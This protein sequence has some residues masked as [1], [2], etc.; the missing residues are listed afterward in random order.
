MDQKPVIIIAG[1]RPEL[2]KT[3]PVYLA[4]KKKKL[5]VLFCLTGQHEQLARQCLDLFGIVPDFDLKIMQA[6][7]G[8]F[9]VTQAVLQK[10][11]DIFT[12][13]KPACVLVQGD[14]TS[15]MAAALS[16]F[17]LKIPIGHIEA[18]LRTHDLY[19]PFPEEANRKII[20]SIAQF[21]FAPTE[22]ARQHLLAEHIPSEAIF[23]T[24]N[25]IVDA[26]HIIQDK[27]ERNELVRSALL[28]HTVAYA[29]KKKQKIMLLT[30]H[31][32]EAFDGGIDTI[33]Q[34]IKQF[35]E[36]NETFFCVYLY[37]PNPKVIQAIKRAQ[38]HS[39]TNLL[40]HEPV[41]YEQMISLLLS[42]DVVVTDSGGLQEEAVSLHKPVLVL[43]EKTERMEAVTQGLAELVGYD[44]QK[45]VHGLEQMLHAKRSASHS[46]N[47]YGDG[48]AAKQIVAILQKSGLALH[49]GKPITTQITLQRRETMKRVCVLGLGYIGLPTAIVLA[50]AGLSV[51]GVDIDQ[52]RVQKI[53]AGD[54]VIKEPE[55]FEKL[56]CILQTNRFCA[57]TDICAADYFIIAVPTPLSSEKKA[58]LS[59]VFSATKTIAGVLK[60]GDT[61]IVESTVSVGTTAQ[62][63]KQLET[64]TGLK[65]GSDF[66]VAHCPERVLPGKI[67]HE[68]IYNDRIVGG[69]N[70]ESTK[71]AVALYKTFVRSSIYE[72]SATSAELVK[73]T[74]NASRDVQIAFAQQVNAMAQ[75]AGLDPYEII[76]LANKHPRVNILKPSCGVGGHC[77]AIDPWF[78]IE[79]FPNQTALL[80]QARIINDDRPKEVIAAIEKEIDSF[81]HAHNKKPVIGLLGLTYKPNVDDLRESPALYIAEQLAKKQAM[82]VADPF[83][84]KEKVPALHKQFRST[85]Q[86]LHE[87]DIVVFLVGHDQFFAIDHKLLLG[88]RVIDFCGFTNE[89]ETTF[90]G[91]NGNKQELVQ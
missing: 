10:T 46:K 38:L 60:K 1:T 68:L 19:A 89:I 67:V 63:A 16:A 86:T 39:C 75:T 45:I 82:T 14:T 17:Y 81:V 8:P 37:H 87:S 76:A 61:V 40:L 66:Y 26:L 52:S 18:G 22:Q 11:K 50:D 59:Y 69:I 48:T 2:I 28:N 72:T 47:I 90:V 88:K 56:Q 73:L 62:V 25:T 54:P 27:L 58:D 3:I 21:H 91:N 30:V 77:I 57:Q 64:Q 7:Q 44:A 53:N 4:L 83:V 49:F 9:Y 71:K 41:S 70:D 12:Q 80:R 15:A 34:T 31:R 79:T 85:M 78:L 29:K 43:R 13:I 32:Q 84:T 74:E 33:L 51:F 5:P 55:I 42:A 35:L 23:L 20:G 36:T 24:G 6:G 65:A